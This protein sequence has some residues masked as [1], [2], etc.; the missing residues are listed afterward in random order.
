MQAVSNNALEMIRKHVV[1]VVLKYGKYDH[2]S[3][4]KSLKFFAAIL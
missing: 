4:I 2:K 3:V 1:N